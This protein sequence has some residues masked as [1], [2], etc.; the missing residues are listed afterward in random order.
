M[1]GGGVD[2]LP[3]GITFTGIIVKEPTGHRLHING[4]FQKLTEA[5]KRLEKIDPRVVFE[6]VETFTG[7]REKIRKKIKKLNKKAGLPGVAFCSAAA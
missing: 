1:C 3:L 6:L 7:D 4:D 2:L 5:K